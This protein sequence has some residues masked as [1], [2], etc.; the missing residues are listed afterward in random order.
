VLVELAAIDFRLLL[1]LR[2]MGII[3]H[4]CVPLSLGGS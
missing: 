2:H 4:A 3:I 1:L